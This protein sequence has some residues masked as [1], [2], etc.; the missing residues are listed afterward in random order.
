MLFAQAGPEVIGWVTAA[1][2]LGALGILGVY[3]LRV[4]PQVAREDH[5][6]RLEELQMIANMLGVQEQGFK[7]RVGKI[8][9]AIE[10]LRDGAGCKFQA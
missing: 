2:N 3:F 4:Q 1:I 8:T 6:A 5:A 9:A 10:E 7:E